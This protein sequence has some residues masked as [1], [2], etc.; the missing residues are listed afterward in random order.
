MTLADPTP[1]GPVSDTP[2]ARALDLVQ[3]C[4]TLLPAAVLATPVLRG[5]PTHVSAG[6][7]W[8]GLAAL[9]AAAA[10]I[11][12]RPEIRVRGLPLFLAV[13]AVAVFHGE[14]AQP[15]F[16]TFDADRSILG[17]ATG[18]VMLLSGASLGERGRAL[19]VR[20]LAILSLAWVVGAFVDTLLDTERSL[21]GMLENTGDLSEA[22]LPGALA[23]LAVV[24]TGRNPARVAWLAAPLLY[25]AY[26]GFVP[27]Y[28]GVVSMVV[29]GAAA[30]FLARG[31]S[32]GRTWGLALGLVL[33]VV[34]LATGARAIADR[35]AA[36]PPTA[37]GT[38]L[39]T[40]AG[41]PAPPTSLGGV[42]FRLRTW[43]RLP[44]LVRDHLWGGVGPGQ[45][46]RTFPPYR[47]PREI[48]RSSF[49]RSA[50]YQTE[51]EHAHNDWLEGVAEFGLL[52]GL[53]WIAFLV[54][55]LLRAAAA[56]RERD[57]TRT[58]LG[59][60]AIGMLAN[61][62]FN[63][64]FL[65]G[66][67]APVLAFATFG[68]LLGTGRTSGPR[69]RRAMLLPILA[70]VLLILHSIRA[71]DFIRH[72][73]AL[74]E[75]SYRAAVDIGG[76]TGHIASEKERI[77]GRAL[78]ACPDSV[79]ALTE[80]A[81]LLRDTGAEDEDVA[82]LWERVVIRRPNRIE[83]LIA[84]GNIAA[85]QRRFAEARERY[86]AA[87]ALDPL[88]PELLANM[89]T[90]ALD[91]GTVNEMD[92]ALERLELRGPIAPGLLRKK[93]AEQLLMG[94]PH[95][96][97]PLLARVEPRFA[98]LTAE[99]ARALAGELADAGAPILADGMALLAN[100]LWAR[101]HAAA[102]RP[103]DAVR[104]YRQALAVSRR[105]AALEF[106]APAVRLELAGAL[107]LDG[108][109][110]GA[111]TTLGALVP[112]PAELIAL[113]AWA[114]QALLDAGLLGE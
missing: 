45:F 53:P 89:L 42:E 76:I 110:Q 43:Q 9:P 24:A 109:E 113:P 77:L 41:E 46:A 37:A 28:A 35:T 98:A 97:L 18:L 1:T 90:L 15:P 5:V 51:V 7:G 21:A 81:A 11:V 114:G 12:R 104:L 72:G 78:A 27:V 95:L 103:H 58:A 3:A 55:A 88:L 59:L 74:S 73:A 56:L 26:V 4:L 34:M 44:A 14:R 54:V 19:F 66:P 69:S 25:A 38:A 79:V 31:S 64:P 10:L 65:E 86:E 8:A 96:G 33:A 108:D 50:P 82:P 91:A 80:R 52:G 30:S 17:L 93:G 40:T 62:G 101:E 57:T 32:R 84:L 47:D 48:E 112:T 94:R 83:A 67:A 61:A 68:A 75:L 100:Q 99:E 87:F 111:R 71:L 16:D 49:G 6:A 92:R 63:S 39:G 2:R 60:A 20:G 106:G 105:Y 29:A 85:R 107:V 36:G 13:I 102:G 70:G 22:A 23:G